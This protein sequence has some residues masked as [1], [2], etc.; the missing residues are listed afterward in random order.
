MPGQIIQMKRTSTSA[1]P[2][3][4]FFA[5]PAYTNVGGVSKLFIGD[6]N[7]AAVEIAGDSFAKLSSPT[8]T[9]SPT[10]PNVTANDSSGKIANTKFVSDAISASISSLTAGV[11]FQGE[12][13]A[14]G[15]PNYPSAV[16]GDLYVISKS[17]KVGGASGMPV[18]KGQMIIALADNDGGL[19]SAV[20]ASWS[21]GIS[22]AGGVTSTSTTST[23][24]NL[25]TM[26][27]TTGTIIKD[28][29]VAI[30]ADGTFT[31]NSDLFLSTQKAIKTYLTSYVAAQIATIPSSTYTASNGLNLETNAFS[32]KSDVT[33]GGKIV[34]VNVSANGVGV[35]VDNVTITKN[36]TGELT[37]SY[38]AGNGLN[39]TTNSFSVKSDTMTGGNVAPV[40]LTANGVG[41]GIDN[42]TITKNGSNQLVATLPTTID[43]GTF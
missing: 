12:I 29:G 25:T 40:S 26:D 42:V 14:S 3:S 6:K 15:G 21:D 30:S 22:I 34:P 1:S 38:T 36:P 33:T 35:T 13:D 28:S 2:T 24:G 31:A 20:G 18:T 4:L 32:V 9:G 5:E 19:E 11:V 37:A 8:F 17:G 39:L 10:V 43:G 16:A 27:G 41:I 7:G 23:V